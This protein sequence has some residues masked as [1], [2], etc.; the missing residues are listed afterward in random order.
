MDP[1]NQVYLSAISAWE[2]AI[3]YRLDRLPL[4]AD[5]RHYIP[6]QRE[7]HKILPLEVDEE[8]ALNVGHLPDIHQDPFDRM[9]IS[10]A[11]IKGMVL[12]TP[13]RTIHKYPLRYLW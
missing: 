9:L 8:S 7:K 13:D 4:P 3:K 10:Q 2:I 1:S 11:L 5:P 6:E 12:V